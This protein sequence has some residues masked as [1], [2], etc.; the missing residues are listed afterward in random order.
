MPYSLAWCSCYD[1]SSFIHSTN[2]IILI[3]V[4]AVVVVG[5]VGFAFMKSRQNSNQQGGVA[6]AVRAPGSVASE[7]AL[8]R[9]WLKD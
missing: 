2:F 9:I 8:C 7:N 6:Y 3:V 4:V 5:G 1:P